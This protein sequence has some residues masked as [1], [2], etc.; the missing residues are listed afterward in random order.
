MN[1]GNGSEEERGR[2]VVARLGN[3]EIRHL[4]GKGGMGAVYL[5][6]ETHLG[7]E[8]AVKV[9]R[10]SLSADPGFVER[11]T[12]EAQAC[13]RLNHPN[14]V[15]VH[16]VGQAGGRHFIV[17]E[18]V[19]GESLIARIQREGC[20][21]W[22]QAVSITDQVAQGLAEAHR[23]GLIHRDIKPRN[24]IIEPSGRAR[25]LDFG[26]ARAVQPPPGMAP[27]PSHL[28]TPLYMSPEQC[29]AG[30]VTPLSDLYSLGVTLFEMLS[31]HVP[32]M[33]DSP[34]AILSLIIEQ[35]F[36]RLEQALPGV[37]L[38]VRQAL[39]GL[40]MKDPAARYPSAE[41]LARDCQ[42]ILSGTPLEFR[43]DINSLYGT[44]LPDPVALR[45]EG[46]RASTAR[47]G[48]DT[49]RGV[50]GAL[51]AALA[52]RLRQFLRRR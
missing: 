5:G 52:S 33:A 47:P 6:V 1:R 42:A 11:F 25:I 22:K 17:M 2:A 9:L 43:A 23:N 18:Y 15:R 26:L 44:P 13:A 50:V 34:E 3:Y 19:R 14:I 35:P 48:N 31:G 28:G 40:V 30:V 51:Q 24:I 4:L 41:M 7:R 37:M 45:T 20:L 36:P 29:R 27:T 39:A 16:T 46:P 12:Q 38:P 32:F 8:V 10:R 21:H 49:A